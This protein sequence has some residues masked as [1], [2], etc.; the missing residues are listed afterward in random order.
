MFSLESKF[1]F[2]CRPGVPCFNTCCQKI[3][4]FL[5]PFDVLRMKKSL[6]MTSDEF[7]KEYTV[8][9]IAEK[10]G[11]PVV[12]LKMDRETGRCPF[13]S[14]AGCRIYADRPWS[15]RMYPLNQQ[16]NGEYGLAADQTRCAGLSEEREWGVYEWLEDQGITV[17]DA[18]EKDFAQIGARLATTGYKIENPKIRD[19]YYTAC[20]N[21]DKFRRF[22]FESS[23]LKVFD[24]DPETIREIQED[25]VELLKFGFRWALFGIADNKSF[26]IKEDV[27]EAKRKEI[28]GS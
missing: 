7:L 3:N 19:M 14:D 10:T 22:V 23:F 26:K 18:I 1:K 11:L 17:Y 25:E 2:E 13:V 6:R 9:L 4:I 27:L 24:I 5:T 15:C 8:A 16:E 20:Y 12:L 28:K 21:L